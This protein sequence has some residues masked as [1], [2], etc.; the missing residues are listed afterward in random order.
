EEGPAHEPSFTVGLFIGK[1]EIARGEGASKQ[2]AERAAAE[3]GLKALG[4]S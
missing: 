4:W 3:A 2:E 1:E